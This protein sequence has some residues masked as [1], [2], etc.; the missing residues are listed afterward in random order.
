[1]RKEIRP[2]WKPINNAKVELFLWYSNNCECLRIELRKAVSASF[3]S[4]RYT[5]LYQPAGKQLILKY[6]KHVSFRG[7][8]NDPLLQNLLG[9]HYWFLIN[10]THMIL[11]FCFKIIRS[12]MIGTNFSVNMR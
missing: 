2:I 6:D 10:T 8:I 3:L 1:M 9:A 7:G 5:G 4:K 11:I 12:I